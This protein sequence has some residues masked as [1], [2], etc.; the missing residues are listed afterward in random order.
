MSEFGFQSLPPMSTI[1][2]FADESEWNI[3]SYM[4]DQHQKNENGNALIVSQMLE[5]FRF[6][7]DFKSLV[8]LSLCAFKQ[9][10]FV[11]ELNIGVD[12]PNELQAFFTGS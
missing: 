5:S 10:E 7:K 12:I 11:M 3:S 1:R 4:M 2:S 8:Y 9:R 6:P